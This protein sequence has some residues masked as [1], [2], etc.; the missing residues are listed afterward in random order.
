MGILSDF[1]GFL[2]FLTDD[3]AYIDNA[4]DWGDS[5]WR[6]MPD[7]EKGTLSLYHLNNR[8][9]KKIKISFNNKNIGIF[10]DEEDDGWYNFEDKLSRAQKNQLREQGYICIKKY[11]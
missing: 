2:T 8:L 3:N 7:K 6:I 4:K 9:Y 10:T 1:F 5:V 11:G